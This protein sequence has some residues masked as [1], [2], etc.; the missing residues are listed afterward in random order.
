MAS[1]GNSGVNG[2]EAR[3]V[4]LCGAFE[5]SINE[6]GAKMMSITSQ[7]TVRLKLTSLSAS[8]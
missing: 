5:S 6:L 2:D 7:K 4:C 8:K 1:G 3:I